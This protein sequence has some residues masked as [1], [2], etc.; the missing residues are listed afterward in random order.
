VKAIQI[1][2]FGGPEVMK[3]VDLPEPSVGGG[4]VLM[5]IDRAGIN[6][7]DVY[8]VE[9]SYPEPA[10]L[11]FVPGTEVV[12]HTTDGR[13]LASLIP[14]N[15]YAQC[16]AVWHHMSF[17]VP[18]NVGDGQALALLVQGITA[19]HLLRTSARLVPGDSVV[20]HAAAGGVGSL[21]VQLAREWGAGRIIATASTAEKRR[22][23][24]DLGADAVVDSASE[25]LAE[26]LRA[27]NRG[28]AVDVVLEMVGGE[29]F[30]ASYA[31]LAPFG[32]LVTYGTVSGTEAK[33]PTV[34]GLMRQSRTVAGFWLPHVLRD[35]ALTSKTVTELYGLA[36]SGRLHPLVGGE[37]PLTQASI[38]HTDLRMRRS[39]GKLVLDPAR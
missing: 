8:L 12:G 6:Y 37:Y 11:P 34:R 38:A 9:N 35:S 1:R 3:V 39:V 4:Q 22:L 13:R 18:D 28:K 2:G 31:A 25:G 10:K 26:R 30:E 23:A 19:W 32:R 27:A 29:V 15:G 5:H 36:A 16:A 21:A 14:R 7:A 17:A 24:E 33:P 20:V